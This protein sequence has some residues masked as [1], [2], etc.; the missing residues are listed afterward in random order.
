MENG[1]F[2]TLIHCL[3]RLA[4]PHQ[5]GGLEDAQL[6]ERFISTRDEAAF[7]VLVWRHGPMVLNVCRRLLHH[8]QDAEDAF[9]ATFLTLV[10]KAASI[11][12]W[13]TVAGWL[14]R[15]AYRVAIRARAQSAR[16]AQIEHQARPAPPKDCVD[17]V[18]WRDL[19]PVLD[20]AV[21]R[22]PDKYR[23]PIVLC[24]LQGKTHQEAARQLGCPLGTVVSRLAR[25]REQLRTYLGRRG[26]ALTVG[27][28]GSVLAEKSFAAALPGALV[29]TTIQGALL[30]SSC[31][32]TA[33]GAIS[34]PVAALTEGALRTMFLTKMTV[35]AAVVLLGCG[36]GTGLVGL[37][38]QSLAAQQP[39]RSTV[40]PGCSA[41]AILDSPFKDFLVQV[42]E[43]QT[44]SFL[45][46]QGV[47][48]DAGLTGSIV[49]NERNF[50]LLR[51]TSGL[52]NF[53][54]GAGQEF[55]TEAVPG[56]QLQRYTITF[57]EPDGA[58]LRWKLEKAKPFYQ[59][60][61]TET[62]QQMEVMGQ[63][64]T[65]KQ[66]QTFYLRWT[67]QGKN[68]EGHWV[69]SQRVEGVKINVD[70]GGTTVQFDS[71]TGKSNEPSP[72]GDFYKALVGAEFQL[73][74]PPGPRGLK[75]EG[76]NQFFR[77]LS[78][79]HVHL[80]TQSIADYNQ[81]LALWFMA[82]PDQPVQ[83]G[84]T[85]TR[86]S[87]FSV[88]ALQGFDATYQYTYAGR[89]GELDKIRVVCQLKY[90]L[91]DPGKSEGFPVSIKNVDLKTSK[92]SGVIFFDRAKGRI[93]QSEMNLTLEGPMTM[94]LDG[95]EAQVNL[96]QTQKT[97]V[98]TTDA[99][100]LTDNPKEEN[101][102]LREENE[103]LKRRLQE[104]ERALKKQ[105]SVTKDPADPTQVF[106]FWLGFFH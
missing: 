20:E 24:Y 79:Q 35:V 65:Q 18:V 72:L 74:V 47:N 82:V 42:K 68:R 51:R 31:G 14:Y 48:S 7:E 13:E 17:E 44:G 39:D 53:F 60:I 27:G 106:S 29:D 67:P 101:Q 49:L 84:D 95:K 28:L 41:P 94:I 1:Q 40:N 19:R 88:T 54:R 99:N 105:P 91:R 64:V 12:K 98:R 103:R 8:T 4:D 89:E 34:A 90:Q 5:A 62:D 71:T 83:V 100:P 56:A 92:G 66:K 81:M 23:T 37:S 3:R 6:L 11:R 73:T 69:V 87:K 97:Q 76:L 58:V 2:R 25:A 16:R 96:R 93:V 78:S 33:A 86:T 63:D 10:R 38:G 75:I 22:L 61:Y 102:R 70:I 52:D 32:G 43:T 80:R 46:G 36:I 15:V 59:E 21:N 9:Q 57:N 30:Y 50:D 45:S 104:I 77:N 26:L 55:R 85:W